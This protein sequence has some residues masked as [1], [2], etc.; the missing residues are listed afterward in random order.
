M[1]I[2]AYI[3]RMVAVKNYSTN[4]TMEK[5]KQGEGGGLRIKNF[6]G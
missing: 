4:T 5:N 1:G 3:K 6:Q 2:G